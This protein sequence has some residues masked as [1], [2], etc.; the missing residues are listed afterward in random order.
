V[1]YENRRGRSG[2]A[3]A[4]D[5]QGWFEDLPKEISTIDEAQAWAEGWFALA[6]GPAEARR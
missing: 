6:R 3:T 5:G 4:S 2:R 1:I